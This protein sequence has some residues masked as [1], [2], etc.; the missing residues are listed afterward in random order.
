MTE[1]DENKKNLKCDKRKD[2]TNDDHMEM[3]MN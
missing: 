2:N 1:E 3:L